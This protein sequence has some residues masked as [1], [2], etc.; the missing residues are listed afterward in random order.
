MARSYNEDVNRKF[1]RDSEWLSSPDPSDL[2]LLKRNHPKYDGSYPWAVEFSHMCLAA[3]TNISQ[4]YWHGNCFGGSN[5]TWLHS[6]N[7]F[8]SRYYSSRRLS[9]V[10][11][12]DTSLHSPHSA[13]CLSE[14][15]A[16][17]RNFPKQ[18]LQHYISIE[19]QVREVNSAEQSLRHRFLLSLSTGGTLAM[20]EPLLISGVDLGRRATYYF[21]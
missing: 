12:V 15:P 17:T 3:G 8:I 7:L 9:T 13:F 16:S 2:A 11:P 6:Y 14:I 5:W 21:E 18:R 4:K 10:R 20:L 1:D 19:T